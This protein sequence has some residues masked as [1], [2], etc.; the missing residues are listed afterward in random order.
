VSFLPASKLTSYNDQN[1][2]LEIIQITPNVWTYSVSN[3]QTPFDLFINEQNKKENSFQTCVCTCPCGHPHIAV[4][5]R[6]FEQ[7][8][9]GYSKVRSEGVFMS[10]FT[11]NHTSALVVRSTNF[12][13]PF[14]SICTCL[15]RR[16]PRESFSVTTSGDQNS[17][18]AIVFTECVFMG[19]I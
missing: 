9:Y 1:A 16:R 5:L 4:F 14:D 7:S 10:S 8:L 12:R 3:R 17:G 2:Y 19:R 13:Y 11:H 15:G 18:V 6:Q